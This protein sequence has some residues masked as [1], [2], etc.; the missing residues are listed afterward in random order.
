MPAAEPEVADAADPSAPSAHKSILKKTPSARAPTPSEEHEDEDHFDAL[1][2]ALLPADATV[3]LVVADWRAKHAADPEGALAELYTL[4][5]RV[6]L[7]FAP[8]FPADTPRAPRAPRARRLKSTPSPFFFL[9]LTRGRFV[10]SRDA[11]Q[12]GGCAITLG[13]DELDASTGDEIG[14]RVVS[15]M[16]AGNVYADDPLDDSGTR[17]SRKETFKHFK[18]HYAEFWDTLLRDSSETEELFVFGDE[19]AEAGAKKNDGNDAGD[20]SGARKTKR[21]DTKKTRDDLGSTAN[22]NGGA[23]ATLFDAVSDAVALFSGSRARTVRVA[24][25]SA[26]L[27]LVS[28]LVAIAKAKAETRDTKQRQ[29]DAESR[30]KRPNAAMTRALAEALSET[31]ARIRGAERMIADAF[32]KI[33]THRFRDVDAHVRAQCMQSIGAW[34]RAH[35]LFFLSDVYL[36]YLGWSLSDKDPRVR[37]AVLAALRAL[38]AASAENLA[39]MDTFNARF[40]PRIAEMLHDVDASVAVEAIGTLAALHAAGVAPREEMQPV[41]ALLLDGDARVRAAAARVVPALLAGDAAEGEGEEDEGI[42]TEKSRSKKKSASAANDDGDAKTRETLMSLVALVRRLGGSRARTAGAVDALWDEYGDAM[43]E[44]GVILDAF[45]REEP[46][47]V[48]SGAGGKKSARGKKA[49]ASETKTPDEDAGGLDAENLAATATA[50]ARDPMDADAAAGLANLLACAARRAC[51]ERLVQPEGAPRPYTKAQR[52]SHARAREAFTQCAIKSLPAALRKW[53][54]DEAVVAPLLETA[55]HL[56]LEHYSLRHKEKAFDELAGVVTEIFRARSGR[57]VLDACAAALHHA[58]AEGSESICDLARRRVDATFAESAEKLR[59]A[60]T[61]AA[62]AAKKGSSKKGSSSKAPAAGVDAEDGAQFRARVE[63]TRL[64]ALLSLMPPPER[65]PTTPSATR[66]LFDDLVTVVT[67]AA[68]AR[69]ALQ[70]RAVALATRAA[71]LWLSHALF[72]LVDR[73]ASAVTAAEV[74]EHVALR[75]AFVRG[76][77][78]LARTSVDALDADAEED[79][80]RAAAPPGPAALGRRAV[81]KAAVAAFAH[82]VVVYQRPRAAAAEAAAAEAARARAAGGGAEG[83]A[84][85]CVDPAAC[86]PAPVFRALELTPDEEAFR[87]A[88]DACNQLL[89]PPETPSAFRV[90]SEE[91]SETLGDDFGDEETARLAYALA[92]AEAAVGEHRFVAAE[93]LANR[94]QSGAWTDHAIASL[95]FDLRRLGPRAVGDVIFY[96]LVSAFDEVT[97]GDRS[98]PDVVVAMEHAFEEFSARLAHMFNVGSARDRAVCRHVVEEG[99]RYAIPTSSPEPEKQ[100]FL[101]LGLAAFVPKLAGADARAFAEPLALVLDGVDAEHADNAPLADFAERVAA[102]AAGAAGKT[103]E[104]AA[105]ARARPPGARGAAAA[106]ADPAEEPTQDEEPVRAFGGGRRR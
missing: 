87:A 17:G 1:F 101:S 69:A 85:E 15:E 80:P 97:G 50:T 8:R 33:F 19:N 49:R 82:L 28:S 78:A 23:S 94:D 45:L 2:G 31:Q 57:R 32:T 37:R 52:E 3:A 93:L 11:P 54:S 41:A 91:A 92:T 53:R 34:M 24:A 102:R 74:K 51:G 88:W 95:L 90:S 26:G 27:T 70:P 13:K 43:S 30:K 66:D 6:R 60:A 9:I 25:T 48:S 75:D 59:A 72:D 89:D 100:P 4:I 20:A 76:A 22:A 14:A 7:A 39:L 38:Y 104:F 73:G 84:P 44:W 103:G 64:N 16:V 68:E 106:R 35:P 83:E 5:A 61:E 77:V 79:S 71:T 10:P 40:Q 47:A 98:D 21:G 65:G 18:K 12:A 56:R 105:Q 46:T 36:K 67:D 63:L 99:L 96:S 62:E 55:R 42:A 81:P 86:E 29:L 58:T